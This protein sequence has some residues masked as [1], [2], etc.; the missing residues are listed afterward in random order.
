LPNLKG[1]TIVAA[2]YD[3]LAPLI[4]SYDAQIVNYQAGDDV[5]QFDFNSTDLAGIVFGTTAETNGVFGQIQDLPEPSTLAAF[6]SALILLA[7]IQKRRSA[8]LLFGFILLAKACGQDQQNGG[9]RGHR[10]TQAGA[11]LALVG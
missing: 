7:L 4:G 11:A 3:D 1:S 5:L 2:F 8:G 10:M 9:A 6:G